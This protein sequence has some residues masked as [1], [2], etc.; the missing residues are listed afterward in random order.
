M[1]TCSVQTDFW[2]PSKEQTWDKKERWS[3]TT[4]FLPIQSQTT[5]EAGA[6]YVLKHKL[7]NTKKNTNIRSAPCNGTGVP[8]K[9]L[10]DGA[11]VKIKRKATKSWTWTSQ[12]TDKCQASSLSEIITLEV[13]L[14]EPL[15]FILPVQMT[16]ILCQCPF[17]TLVTFYSKSLQ[18]CFLN[19][20]WKV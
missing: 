1:S 11:W 6:T 3:P 13:I 12:N 4:T 9:V 19:Q 2:F 8:H 5:L 18:L 14:K 10:S 20:L 7:K 15:D 16:T 17:W